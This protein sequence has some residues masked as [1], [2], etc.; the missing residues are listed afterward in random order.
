MT[1][2]LQRVISGAQTGADQAGLF[3]AEALAI[4]TG[5]TCPLGCRTES[6]DR[7]DLIARFGLTESPSSDYQVRTLANVKAASGTAV[8]GDVAETGSALTCRLVRV[9]HGE[10][11][12]KINPTALELREWILRDEIR[13][14][15]IAGNRLSKLGIPAY[16]ALVLLLVDAL[17]A[18]G[19]LRMVD[20]PLLGR[21]ARAP[22]RNGWMGTRAAR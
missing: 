21:V 17:I 3:T 10:G 7:R 19:D 20:P 18:P 4:P 11:G 13:V 15:N 9:E 2:P 14:L 5:G 22:R 12:L 6:G 1:W 8:F 16:D